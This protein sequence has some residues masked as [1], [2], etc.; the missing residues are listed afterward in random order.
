MIRQKN[1]TVLDM[2]LLPYFKT[3]FVYYLWPVWQYE[4]IWDSYWTWICL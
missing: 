1:R 3:I 2:M 4:N